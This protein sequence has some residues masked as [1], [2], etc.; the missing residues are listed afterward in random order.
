MVHDVYNIKLNAKI[1]EDGMVQ[2][3]NPVEEGALSCHPQHMYD[4][5][6]KY[7]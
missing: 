7:M 3:I 1:Q 4:K 6:I 5:T 2:V